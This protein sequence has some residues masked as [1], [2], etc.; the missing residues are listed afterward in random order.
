MVVLRLGGFKPP[1]RIASTNWQRQLV[2]I[3]FIGNVFRNGWCRDDSVAPYATESWG[4][5]AKTDQPPHSGEPRTSFFRSI[6]SLSSIKLTQ[7]PCGIISCRHCV[8]FPSFSIKL[9][10]QW[11]TRRNVHACLSS[12]Q[13]AKFNCWRRKF[14]IVRRN[15]VVGTSVTSSQQKCA[16]WPRKYLTPVVRVHLLLWLWNWMALAS[17]HPTVFCTTLAVLRNAAESWEALQ[18]SFAFT[19]LVEGFNDLLYIIIVFHPP[20]KEMIGWDTS[21]FLGC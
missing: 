15:E 14:S 1:G 17:W 5:G 8:Y 19:V 4:S 3:A 12:L 7:W 9:S 11:K 2:A 10:W 20:K 18:N 13:H 21:R 16:A 6:W